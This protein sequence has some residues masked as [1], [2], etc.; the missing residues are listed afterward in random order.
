MKHLL[1]TALL[2]GAGILAGQAQNVV[3]TDK[4]GIA[5]RFH[6][7]YVQEITFEK[8][9][10]GDG[11]DLRFSGL[12]MD[13]WGKRNITL[14]FTS[15]DETKVSL[16]IYQPEAMYLQPGTYKV[17]SSY[18][19]YTVDPGYSTIEVDGNKEELSSGDMVVSLNGETYTFDINLILAS[20]KSL[21][22]AYTGGLSIFG[23]VINF[24]ITG[25]SYNEINDPAPNGFYYKLN[26]ANWKMEM[27]LGLFSEG[28]APTPGVY[29]FSD[30]MENGTATSTVELYSPYNENTKFTD[31]TVTVSGE[32]DDMEIVIEGNLGFG[33]PMK[34]VYKGK[35]PARPVASLDYDLTFDSASVVTFGSRN[36]SVTLSAGDNMV[37]FDLYQPEGLY[38]QPGTYKIEDTMA[39]YT[40]DP[41]YINY[42]G[43]VIDGTTMAITGGS[44]VIELAGNVYTIKGDLTFDGG[45]LK[46]SYTGELD[47]FGPIVTF[48][49]TGCI[50]VSLNE[51]AANGFYYRFN[52]ESYKL[53]MR[54]DIF[55]S[56]ET[57]AA[58]TYTFSDTMENGTASSAVDL[59]EPYIGATK[60]TEGTVV[61]SGEGDATV[62]EVEGTLTEGLVLKAR[63]VGSLPARGAAE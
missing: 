43:I 60:F 19:D 46:F 23:P 54:L 27:R 38:L 61:I 52:D 40:I 32:G 41:T 21:K 12:E 53:E 35:L 56:G 47:K 51:P 18:G 57:P 58:G 37:Y 24:D 10:A 55:S 20:G 29:T 2:C 15:G 7:D 34:A 3:I 4:D 1:T 63:Y 13:V 33:M 59:Y 26:D 31:G 17:D 62:V 48:E 16:D 36:E 39:D 11:Y 30:T 45:N 22:G 44:V 49:L 25:C 14:S 6:A 50:Y 8:L 42:S 9:Q 5:H 28:N